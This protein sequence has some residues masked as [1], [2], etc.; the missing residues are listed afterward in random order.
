MKP[1]LLLPSFLILRLCCKYRYSVKKAV[2]NARPDT[3]PQISAI[4][5]R[6][7]YVEVLDR[8][9]AESVDKLQDEVAGG[10][11]VVVDPIVL[12]AMVKVTD[13]KIDGI[14]IP[15]AIVGLGTASISMGVTDALSR[16]GKGNSAV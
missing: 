8:S 10:T 2:I 13:D 11:V 15:G 4:T 3:E 12:E 6:L 16:R 9:F 5:I 7:L 1:V 14:E